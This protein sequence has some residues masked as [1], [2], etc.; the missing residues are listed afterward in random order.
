MTLRRQF[1]EFVDAVQAGFCSRD[2]MHKEL[3]DELVVILTANKSTMLK[4]EKKIK[5]Q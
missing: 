1:S 2:K 3:R 5:L 4:Q